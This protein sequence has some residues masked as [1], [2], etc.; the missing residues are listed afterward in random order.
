MDNKNP[1]EKKNEL[2]SEDNVI[3]ISAESQTVRMSGR[4]KVL[5]GSIVLLVVLVGGLFVYFS[6]INRDIDKKAWQLFFDLTRGNDTAL[7]AEQ[8][9]T[10]LP[11]GSYPL[12]ASIPGPIKRIS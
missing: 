7:P 3:E 9:A 4:K 12:T 6:Y 11:R 10:K 5:I 2:F 8:N 1:G